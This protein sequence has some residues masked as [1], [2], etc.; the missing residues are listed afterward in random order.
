M[1]IKEI[2]QRH[3]ERK[4]KL[5]GDAMC[6][7]IDIGILGADNDIR[8]LLNEVKRLQTKLIESAPNCG[9]KMKGK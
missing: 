2:E 4:M 7:E 9:A 8:W 5:N 3:I 1:N 6:G